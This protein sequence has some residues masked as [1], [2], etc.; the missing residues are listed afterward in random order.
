[1]SG[2]FNRISI[3]RPLKRKTCKSNENG[4]RNQLANN[5]NNKEPGLMVQGMFD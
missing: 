5:N 2:A 4:Y 1:M 3:L